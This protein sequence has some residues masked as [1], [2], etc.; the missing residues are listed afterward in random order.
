MSR[1]AAQPFP[2]APSDRPRSIAVLTR[3]PRVIL[4]ALFLGAHVPGALLMG[5]SSIVTTLHAF[6]VVAIGVAVALHGRRLER[7]AYVAAY[8]TGAEVLWRMLGAQVFWEFGKYATS[9]IF[10]LAILRSRKWKAPVQVLLYFLLLLPS[11]VLT[12]GNEDLVSAKSQLSFALSGPFSLLVSVW[13]FHQIKLTT[14]QIQRVFLSTIGP[15]LS[16]A[17]ITYLFARIVFSDVRFGGG[18]NTAMSGGFAPNQVSGALGL[19]VLLG[20]LCLLRRGIGLQWQ[21]LLL[22][23]MVVLAVQSAATFSRGGLYFVGGAALVASFFLFR[24]AASRI[25]IIGLAIIVVLAGYFVLL[26]YLDSFTDGA[27]SARFQD[28]DLTDRD[29]LV[30]V[31]FEIWFDNPVFG[32]GPGQ[33]N[34]HRAIYFE[35]KSSHT[36]FTRLLSEH[37]VFGALALLLLLASAAQNILRRSRSMDGRALAASLECWSFLFMAAYGMRLVAP[38]YIYGLAFA[39]FVD[40]RGASASHGN[41]APANRV[42]PNY[43]SRQ[44][45][46]N[47]RVRRR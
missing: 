27:L 42:K 28:V 36:E 5:R 26:P 47:A 17:A 22:G 37:G 43:N 32:I 18:S 14:D 34:E 45:S 1:V 2:V 33:A 12:L 38:S 41:K 46:S 23:V 11:A 15:L 20:F 29:E 16:I 10:L 6:V 7:V 31:D 3:P 40:P 44:V 39:E 4:W 24:D 35:Q 13:F 8:I 9:V 25:R 21:I 30:R 19:G